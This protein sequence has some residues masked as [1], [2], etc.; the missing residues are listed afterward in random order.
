GTACVDTT[1]NNAHCGECSNACDS[2]T[3]QCVAGGCECREGLEL[4]LDE[5]VD[6]SNDS[7]HCG[8]CGEA[9]GAAES[10]AEGECVTDPL[11]SC[12][13]AQLTDATYEGILLPVTGEN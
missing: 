1:T 11:L 3:E 7:S 10:C 9:C 4:C 13:D 8:S 5:C 12:S 2:A 6:V